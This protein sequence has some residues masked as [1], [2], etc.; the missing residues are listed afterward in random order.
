MHDLT[1][2]QYE[3]LWLSGADARADMQHRKNYYDGKH[4]IIGQGELY[5]DGSKK[6]EKVSNF[7]KFGIDLYTGSIAGTPYNITDI[8]TVDDTEEGEDVA[9]SSEIYRDIG[10]DNNFDSLDTGLLR[11]ALIYG[12]GLETHEYINDEIVITQRDPL[13]WMVVYNSDGEK[14]GVINRSTVASG[15]FVGDVMLEEPLEILVVY[16]DTEIITFHKSSSINE[17][18][19][20]EPEQHP[21]TEHQYG[22]VPVV[23]FK[24][25]EEMATHITDDLIGQQDEYNEIDSASGDDIKS[26][27]DGILA[28]KGFDLAHIREN[29]ETIRESKLLP[30]PQEG[31]AFYIKKGSDEVRT[32]SRLERTRE[33]IF[34][35]LIVP[36]IEQI[37]GSVGSTSG[38]ALKLKFKPMS[39][40][41]S[42]M[43]ANIRPGIRERITLMNTRLGPTGMGVIE[44][45]QVNID[46]TL[47]VNRIEEWQNI[48]AT[49]GIVS[50]TK[51]LEMMSDVQDPEQEQKRLDAEQENSRFIDRGAGTPDE[52]VANNDAEIQA[53]AVNVQPQLSTVIDAVS[54]AAIAETL[55][56]SKEPTV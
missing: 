52:V 21:R 14:I 55:R 46:F 48:A 17:G 33:N 22:A 13:A 40:K 47:P 36:D 2:E 25:N 10:T 31:D 16:T 41:A 7:V 54:D 45:Y 38:I 29:S 51:Q 26:D 6:S 5:A 19:W 27:S 24:I 56:R 53:L 42:Y 35:G 44:N 37:V 50:H 4:A 32:S 20:F 12:H 18:K 43:I 15:A 34:M 8:E 28:I 30:L 23:V 49:T 3:E 1:P 39:D 9:G 11:D